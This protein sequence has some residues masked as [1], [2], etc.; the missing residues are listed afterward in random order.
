MSSA[1][2]HPSP[3]RHPYQQ[4]SA[5]ET[6]S[7][8]VPNIQSCA[9]THQ[10]QAVLAWSIIPSPRKRSHGPSVQYSWAGPECCS[11][12]HIW[13]GE[14]LGLK[15]GLLI[16]HVSVPRECHG[17]C[18]EQRCCTGALGLGAIRA[19]SIPEEVA[20]F[21]SQCPGPWKTSHHL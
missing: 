11:S 18:P 16:V 2:P 15:S 19:F 4:H 3:H 5:K 14:S 9:H 21:K 8:W 7:C 12:P 1:S 20:G 6:P 17:Q 13:V 10:G